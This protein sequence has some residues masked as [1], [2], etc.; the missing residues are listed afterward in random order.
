MKPKNKYLIVWTSPHGHEKSA[1][2]KRKNEVMRV[3]K[4]IIKHKNTPVF[5]YNIHT[6]EMINSNE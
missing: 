1:L 4:D 3:F 2:W 6:G 5:L